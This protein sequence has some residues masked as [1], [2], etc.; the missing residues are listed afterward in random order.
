[1][2]SFVVAL[3]CTLCASAASA[4][5]LTCWYNSSGASTGAD[6]GSMDVP[7]AQWGLS[8]AIPNPRANGTD[9]YAYVIIL[10]SYD[11]GNDCPET[12]ELR[13]E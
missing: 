1:M 11:S 12:A 8:Y 2:R 4:S 10:P 7:E 3:V 6:G 9:D 5:P 13:A